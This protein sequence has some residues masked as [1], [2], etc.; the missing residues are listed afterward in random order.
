MA[1]VPPSL[2]GPED[3]HRQVLPNGITV[4]ARAN[5]NSSAVSMNGYIHVGSLAEPDEKLGLADFTASALMR[6]TE[7]RTFD[8][9]FNALES[10]GASFGYDSGTHTTSFGGRALAEDLGLLLEL[11]SE[12]LR[13]PAFP[14]HEVEK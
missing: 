9:I 3:I 7:E 5:F 6:G 1:S 14:E 12:T 2:P 4:L 13:S 11:L 8:E 10:V